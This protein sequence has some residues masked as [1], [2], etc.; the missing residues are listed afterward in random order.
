MS[1]A[2][3]GNSNHTLVLW[4]GASLMVRKDFRMWGHKAA[5]GLVVLVIKE[6]D[7]VAAEVTSF[8]K[9]WLHS[10]L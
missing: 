5:Q 6:T 8:L 7:L 1:S 2:L 10:V 9:N 4:A 3:K